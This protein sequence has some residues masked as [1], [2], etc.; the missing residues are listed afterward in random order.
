[1]ILEHRN[2]EYVY[3]ITWIMLR[4]ERF[5]SRSFVSMVYKPF[6]TRG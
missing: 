1:M 3:Y 5:N 6:V 4:N 2:G